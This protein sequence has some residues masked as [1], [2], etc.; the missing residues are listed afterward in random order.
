MQSKPL[1][2]VFCLPGSSF[3]GKFL[4]RWTD[5]VA[6][7]LSHGIRPVLSRRE[8]CNIYYVRNMCLGADVSRGKDQKPFDGKLDY[9]FIMWIDSDILFTPQQFMKLLGHNTDIVSGVYLMEDGKSLATVQDWDEEFFKEKKH[10]R[11]MTISDLTPGP[12]PAERGEKESLIEVAYTGMGFML[13]KKGVFEKLEYP[14]FRP[15][16]KKIGDMVDFTMEDAA[17]CLQAREKKCKITIDPEVRVG[18]EK[19]IVL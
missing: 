8:S 13:V 16:E 15:I 5:L 12:S 3:S 2:V 17:F 9:D 1:T 19:K 7:C 4:E 10:F 18:H 14:W 11:F 6:Y